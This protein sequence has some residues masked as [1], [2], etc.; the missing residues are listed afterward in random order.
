MEERRK[1]MMEEG[2]SFDQVE[3]LVK[4][5]L[6]TGAKEIAATLKHLTD[7]Q[8]VAVPPMTLLYARSHFKCPN[9]AAQHTHESVHEAKGQDF[10]LKQLDFLPEFCDGMPILTYFKL[11]ENK[12]SLTSLPSTSKAKIFKMIQKEPQINTALLGFEGESNYEVIKTGLLKHFGALQLQKVLTEFLD[13]KQLENESLSEFA[14]R[15]S[16]VCQG[17]EQYKIVDIIRIVISRGLKAI[18]MRN[19]FLHQTSEAIAGSE[20][21]TLNSFTSTLQ[22]L[23]TVVSSIQYSSSRNR[24]R[25]NKTSN[26]NSSGEA[27]IKEHST[28]NA[29]VGHSVPKQ[30]YCYYCKS[31]DHWSNKCPKPHRVGTRNSYTHNPGNESNSSTSKQASAKT[32]VFDVGQAT[33]Q[34]HTSQTLKEI[35]PE[36]KQKITVNDKDYLAKLD[37]GANVSFIREDVVNELM[38]KKYEILEK[39]DIQL[40][41]GRVFNPKEEVLVPLSFPFAVDKWMYIAPLTTTPFLLGTDSFE[42]LK[43]GGH[44]LYL[45]SNV[46]EDNITLE[47]PARVE[48]DEHKELVESQVFLPLQR[49]NNI[50][51]ESYCTHPQAVMPIELTSYEPI[52]HTPAKVPLALQPELDK[53]LTQLIEAKRI[54]VIDGPLKFKLRLVVVAKKADGIPT[55]RLRL[56]LDTRLLNLRLHDAA[57]ELPNIKDVLTIVAKKRVFSKIDLTSAFF[58]IKLRPE[59]RHLFSFVT[60]YEGAMTAFQFLVAPMGVKS[61]PKHFQRIISA[62]L[63]DHAKFCLC[64][65]DDV[66]VFS[67]D[68]NIHVQ[69]V[70]TILDVLT[71]YSLRISFD[72]SHFGYSTIRL[73][74]HLVSYNSITVDPLK[75]A[76]IKD[77]PYPTNDAELSSFLGFFSYLKPFIINAAELHAEVRKHEANMKSSEFK[78]SIDKIKLAVANSIDTTPFNPNLDTIVKVDASDLAIG[79]V[80]CQNNKIVAASS[81]PLL[82]FEKNY[83][84]FKKETRAMLFGLEKFHDYLWGHS[85]VIESDHAPLQDLQSKSVPLPRSIAHWLHEILQ[86]DFK[87]RFIPGSSNFLADALSRVRPTDKTT[88]LVASH[89]AFLAPKKKLSIA[90]KK[91]IIKEVHEIAHSNIAVTLNE[92]YYRYNLSFANITKLTAEIVR[93]C[94]HCLKYNSAPRI[95]RPYEV[96]VPNSVW[97]TVQADLK[98]FEP[99]LAGFKY[100]MVMTC[101]LSSFTILKVLS[102]KTADSTLTALKEIFANYGHPA[103]MQ[104]D[105]G[106]ELMNEKIKTYCVENQTKIIGIAPHSHQAQG[107]VERKIRDVSN[108]ILKKCSGDL[109]HWEELVSETQLAL[110]STLS[111]AIKASPAEY[112]FGRPLRVTLNADQFFDPLPPEEKAR[113]DQIKDVSTQLPNLVSKVT[114]NRQE[115]KQRFDHSHKISKTHFKVGDRVYLAATPGHAKADAKFTGP[116]V[117]KREQGNGYI[118]GDIDGA[119]FPNV[120]S[121]QRLKRATHAETDNSTVYLLEK[122]L[123]H[124]KVGRK[125]LYLVKWKNFDETYN[126]WESP[127][128]F[129]N[130]KPIKQYWISKK[131]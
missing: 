93:S 5:L 58:Q 64:Y 9:P 39:V 61:V 42:K 125:I 31:N 26:S 116:Y 70:S 97:S 2:K 22:S 49:N 1:A 90:E 68:V 124:K 8:L 102:D 77:W 30:P 65:I 82:S 96:T 85:F 69:H 131:T 3:E 59:D 28:T 74:G 95:Y 129:I 10:N 98:E 19:T 54:Q 72:K 120:I 75:S 57:F 79:A 12:F 38:L 41:D 67:E 63:R 84:V 128:N 119:E 111:N 104:I 80:L 92:L 99:S 101:C 6:P 105:Q 21:Q 88:S 115:N 103:I 110:N 7:A 40:A 121:S 108:L 50:P 44:Y 13:L 113:E 117:I 52:I 4:A 62:I 35:G 51:E 15:V 86:Y 66:I 122:I 87:I 123:D 32:A 55:G 18:H 130:R 127:S 48:K 37:S 100:L 89:A 34:V 126:S 81:R 24:T 11:F 60:T 45:S 91:E 16:I 20:S 46:D 83:S 33:G 27:E 47:R 114:L 36:Y 56:C 112:F 76:Q 25:Y 53:T 118:V 23:E 14:N 107:V 78:T 109:S 43:I 106:R 71:T 73:L 17:I 94:E 29:N